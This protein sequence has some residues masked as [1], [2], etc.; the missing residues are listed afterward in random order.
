MMARK[1]S[2][3]AEKK[4]R[5]VHPN[6][7]KNLKPFTGGPDPRR[8]MN[9]PTPKDAAELNAM[10]DDLFAE[11]VPAAKGQKEKR[12]KAVI[13]ELLMSK[14]PSGPIHV[15]DRRFGKVAQAV[16]VTS[17]GEKIKGYVGINPDDWD[18]DEK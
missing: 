3:T 12:V 11:D 1:K 4:Q 6:S 18:K 5:Q 16:D 7:L 17:G 14:N 9:G 13:R 15:L 8:N 2:Q 10:I